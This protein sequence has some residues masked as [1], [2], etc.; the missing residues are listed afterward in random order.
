MTDDPDK[1]EQFLRANPG[2]LAGRPGLYGVLLPPV[3]VHGNKVADH[4][5]AQIAAGRAALAR[6]KAEAAGL[7]ATQRAAA[8]M[9]ARVQGAVLALIAADDVVDCV[10]NILPGLM[11]VDNAVLCADAPTPGFRTLPAGTVRRLLQGRLVQCR[12][13][14]EDAALLHAE[15]AE[16]AVRDVLVR[17]PMARPALLAMASRDADAFSGIGDSEAYAF[18]GR[19]IAARLG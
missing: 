10:T 7:L 13:Q 11:A 1:I 16:L 3:R 8:A 5:A 14:P 6:E 12:S 4:M 9:L 2:F 15:A 19:V 17:L 18:L